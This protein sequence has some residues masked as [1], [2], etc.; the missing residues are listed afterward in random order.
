MKTS[1][2]LKP[3][4]DNNRIKKEVSK[5]P[6]AR[7]KFL[8]SNIHSISNQTGKASKFTDAF[9]VTHKK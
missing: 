5:R 2:K 1:E 9:S 4:S 7:R 6:K 3:V 8:D